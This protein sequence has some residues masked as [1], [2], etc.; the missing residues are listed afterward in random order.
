MD[1]REQ[2]GSTLLTDDNDSTSRPDLTRF[3]QSVL[4][5]PGIVH[6]KRLFLPLLAPTYR[7]VS[8]P[9]AGRASHPSTKPIVTQW[10]P[11]SLSRIRPRTSLIDDRDQL[12]LLEPVSEGTPRITIE[13]A[14]HSSVP[15]L[16]L[17]P[18]TSTC[19]PAYSQ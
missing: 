14:P 9:H 10:T 12:K 6:S 2:R 17:N 16:D 18:T 1:Q 7:I 11:S 19:L 4:R 8:I 5:S 13:G 15:A 3:D